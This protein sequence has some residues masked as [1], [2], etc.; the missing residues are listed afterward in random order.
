M[1]LVFEAKGIKEAIEVFDKLKERVKDQT[2]AMEDAARYM[3]SV[4]EGHLDAGR[5]PG[6]AWPTFSPMTMFMGSVSSD[7]NTTRLLNNTGEL[8]RSITGKSG[9]SWATVTAEKEENGVNI[10]A[11]HHFGARINVS[12]KQSLW[13][14]SN[15][16]VNV[17]GQIVIPSRQFLWLEEKN[18]EKLA[19][20][21]KRFIVDG[22]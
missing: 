2:P 22:K 21:V 15:F 1:K 6:G 16:G 10:A 17:G 9:S 11:V 19:E 20:N 7:V 3:S 4:A 5:N 12:K 14:R 8:K 18:V 13:F